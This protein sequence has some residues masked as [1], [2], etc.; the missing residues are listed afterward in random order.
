M[1]LRSVILALLMLPLAAWPSEQE[2]RLYVQG[3]TCPLC[4]AAVNKALR[5]TP[6]VQGAKTNLQQEQAQVQV[7]ADFDV[8][9]LLAAIKEV[10]YDAE[11]IQPD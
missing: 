8:E 6:G 9:I 2:V 4:V 5:S 1:F 10:G 11:I 3:M 7:P